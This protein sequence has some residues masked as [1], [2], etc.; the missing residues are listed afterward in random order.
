MR[1]KIPRKFPVLNLEI[2]VGG[3]PTSGDG[4]TWE[5]WWRAV[6][7]LGGRAVCW[8]PPVPSSPFM[9]GNCR[10]PGHRASN[11][12]SA[13]SSRGPCLGPLDGHY[14]FCSSSVN[15]ASSRT[16]FL[17]VVGLSDLDTGL[18]YA[19]HMVSGDAVILRCTQ[20]DP[21]TV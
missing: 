14:R 16:C 6:W 11:P 4:A 20:S 3:G 18:S 12:C 17:L 10:E 8:A 5:G 9:V 1:K 19:W 21:C 13:P 2:W 15:G 7:R